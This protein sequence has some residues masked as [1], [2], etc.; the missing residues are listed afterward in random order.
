[1]SEFEDRLARDLADLARHAVPSE[2]PI[3][4]LPGSARVPDRAPMRFGGWKPIL[5]AV[6]VVLVVGAGW[7][8]RW[9]AGKDYA[10]PA[11]TDSVSPSPSSSESSEGATPTATPSR[12]LSATVSSAPPAVDPAVFR[13]DGVGPLRLGMSVSEVEALGY[14]GGSISVYGC[15]Q[16]LNGSPQESLSVIVDPV[17]SRVVSIGTMFDTAPYRT[18]LGIRVGSTAAEVRAAYAG[19]A[20]TDREF[21]QASTGLLITGPSTYLGFTIK[22]GVVSG[23]KVANAPDLAT[24]SE[25]SCS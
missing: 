2:R 24:N 21:G 15:A 3:P 7:A 1:M 13:F 10:R 8:L 4:P 14:S 9:P 23:M 20:I 25:V 16:Y 6:L 17:L 22:D 18:A 12:T 11:V 5:A 19:Y